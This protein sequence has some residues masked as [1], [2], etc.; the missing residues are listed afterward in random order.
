MIPGPQ[1]LPLFSSLHRHDYHV[2]ASVHH[3][4]ACF[5]HPLYWYRSREH[6]H[7]VEDGKY[8]KE[9]DG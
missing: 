4:V 8:N 5:T 7:E 6:Q 9:V 3:I 1:F 2:L